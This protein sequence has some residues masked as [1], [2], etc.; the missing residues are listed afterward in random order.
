MWAATE[1]FDKP[2]FRCDYSDVELLGKAVTRGRLWR[3]VGL[4]MHVSNG[5]LFGVVYALVVDRLPGPRPLRG[6][7]AGM[8]EHLGSWPGVALTDR[9]HPARDQ[10]VTMKGNRNAF[11]Q[12]TWRHL[13]F[14]AA[15][16][17][18]ESVLSSRE[19]DRA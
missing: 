11:R 9:F 19:A 17:V 4:A 7:L 2:V 13:L 8:L 15:L 12:A 18:F 3:P 10:L 14:G 1:P 16:G 5:A 6:V